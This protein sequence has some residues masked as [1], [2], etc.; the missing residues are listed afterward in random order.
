MPKFNI[1]DKVEISKVLSFDE[2]M[3]IYEGDIA[4]ITGIYSNSYR[5]DV[6]DGQFCWH[7]EELVLVPKTSKMA[8]FINEGE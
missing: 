6:D 4:T 3:Q 5:L 2:D 8:S 7:E 1:G